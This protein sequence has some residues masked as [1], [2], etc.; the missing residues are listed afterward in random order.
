MTARFQAGISLI[1]VMVSLGI[2]AILLG[3]GL[4]S[5]RAYLQN[6]QTRSAAESIMNGLQT[7]RNESIRRNATYE[8]TI[9]NQTAWDI[10][11]AA[12]DTYPCP[13]SRL[14]MR[15]QNETPNAVS[16]VAPAGADTVAFNGLGRVIPNANGTASLTLINVSNPLVTTAQGARPLRILILPGGAMRLCDP[17]VAAGD[18]RACS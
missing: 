4:P 7:T 15:D 14:M 9:H 16:T 18:P 13:T 17:A 6:T 11:P 1:E 12:T 3:L 10:C 5:F 2:L 8:F